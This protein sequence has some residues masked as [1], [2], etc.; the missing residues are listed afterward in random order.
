MSSSRPLV[1]SFVLAAV[2]LGTLPA[3]AHD[4][5]YGDAI[6]REFSNQHDLIEQGIRSRELTYHETAML[7]SEQSNIAALIAR[8]RL[9]GRIDPF[10]RRE[11]VAA[12]AVASKHI[13]IEKHDTEV[14]APARRFGWWHRVMW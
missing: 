10:E 7:R 4:V 2:T 3:L 9:D 5:G 13:T 14:A 12:Q 6:D 8:A 1:L 11:I